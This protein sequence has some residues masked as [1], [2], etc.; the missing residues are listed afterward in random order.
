LFPAS[1][2]VD[3]FAEADAASRSRRGSASSIGHELQP[4]PS[5]KSRG[6]RSG[7]VISAAIANLKETI[8]EVEEGPHQDEMTGK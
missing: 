3:D 2:F 6:S 1:E 5:P 7:S 8:S 4:P